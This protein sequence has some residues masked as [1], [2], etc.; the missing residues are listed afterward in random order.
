MEFRRLAMIRIGTILIG[1]VIAV[2]MAVNGFGV[3]SLVAKSVAA[4]ITQVG[5]MWYL[6]D[7]KP[8]FIW[9][10]DALR[11]L[12]GFSLNLFGFRVFNYWMT[13]AD[14]LL[15]GKYLG[16]ASLGI[17]DRAFG[18]MRLPLDEVSGVL[19]RVMFPAL[20][21]IQRDKERIKGIFLKSNRVIAL[22]TFPLMIGL[23]VVA[24]S[25][26]IAIYGP[27]WEG[28][29]PILQIFCIEGMGRSIGTTKGWIFLTQGRTDLMFKW[30]LFAGV[31]R[32]AS[33]VIGL[34]WGVVGVAAAIVIGG[35]A[36]LW[37]PAWVIPGRLIN[38]SFR[39]ALANLRSPLWC[40]LAMALAVAGVGFMLPAHWPHW[41]RLTAQVPFGIV[42][43]ALLI[44]IFGIRAYRE[45]RELAAEQWQVRFSRSK[46]TKT[47]A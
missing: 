47:P 1:G 37:Y 3:W 29:I 21:T 35:Y 32:I 18:L 7:W 28:V 9:S 45:M 25:F 5:I 12:L 8:R 26:I 2:I 17:Y 43:Y 14:N 34:H 4:A 30:G 42:L 13:N 23:L 46:D 39:E 31:V 36:I 44:H 24:R 33:I 22:I 41:A 10:L 38:L 11:E 19:S 27:K 20:S 6:S 40:S 15:I 16:T